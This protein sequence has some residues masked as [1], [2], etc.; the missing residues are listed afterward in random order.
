MKSTEALLFKLQGLRHGNESIT[1]AILTGKFL[2]VP[3]WEHRGIEFTEMQARL[4]NKE[5]SF[6]M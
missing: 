1:V 2:F 6:Y 3:E 4:I 5:A